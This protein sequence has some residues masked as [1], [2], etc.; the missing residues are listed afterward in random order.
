MILIDDASGSREL[1][2]CPILAPI[3]CLS[4]LP[5]TATS[6][7]RTDLMF[8]GNGPQGLVPIGV[9][10]KHITDL[11]SSLETGRLQATQLPA[12]CELYPVRWLV[13][14]GNYQRGPE[15][16]GNLQTLRWV[17]GKWQY[18]DFAPGNKRPI[19]YSFPM[20]FLASP[21]FL[22]LDIN[23]ITLPERCSHKK[24]IRLQPV[25]EWIAKALYPTWT[26][27]YSSHKSLRVLDGSAR[28]DLSLSRPSLNPGQDARKLALM[29]VLCGFPMVRYERAEALADHFKTLRKFMA[30]TV[31][32]IAEVKV[33]SDSG[34]GRKIGMAVA[35]RID[36]I[37]GK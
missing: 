8:Y 31:E 18:T 24:E 12:L 11:A 30:A 33:I 28:L 36:D 21:S 7:S 2:S 19:S 10:V 37:R 23:L 1:A 6:E 5:C 22:S 35:S 17:D 26:R 9:E 15:P 32:E 3:S 13:I 27:P 34:R 16:D 20:S 29:N 14:Y 4:T 25:A